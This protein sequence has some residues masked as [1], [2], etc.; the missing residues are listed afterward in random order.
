MAF[1]SA[2]GATQRGQDQMRK[3]EFTAVILLSLAIAGSAWAES[4][5]ERTLKM[6]SPPDRMAQ[7]CDYT[8]MTHIRKDQRQFRPDRAVANARSDV[9]ISGDMIEAKGGAFRSR[10]KWYA[11]SYTC[12][13]NADHLNV[14]S[15]KYKIGDEI[16]QE[17]WAAYGLWQ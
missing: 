4:R 3:R 8:A 14:L 1:K 15:F 9:K 17:K 7:L 6:L 11:L 10:G 13:T 16:P 12:K 5:F 2:L